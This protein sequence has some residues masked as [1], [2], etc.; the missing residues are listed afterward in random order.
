[1]LGVWEVTFCLEAQFGSA[2]R[3]VF[4]EVRKTSKKWSSSGHGFSQPE[5]WFFFP[6]AMQHCSMIQCAGVR[7]DSGRETLSMSGGI[8]DVFVNKGLVLGERGD[9]RV[10]ELLSRTR[11]LEKICFA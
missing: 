6:N 2:S 1:M 3:H 8:I 10:G 5:G 7:F 4:L 9:R 11:S